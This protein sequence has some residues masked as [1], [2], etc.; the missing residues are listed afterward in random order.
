[1]VGRTAELSRLE[2]AV[3]SAAAGRGTVALVPGEAGIGKTRLVSELGDRV[4]LS[5]STVLIGTCVAGVGSGLPYL[6][7][8]EAL[9]PLRL[10]AVLDELTG[11]LNELVQLIP[12]LG[13]AGSASTP[14]RRADRQLRIFRE[15]VELLDR[16][17]GN[18]ATVLVLEDLHWADASTLGLVSYLAHAVR[19]HRI[20]VVATYR[21]DQPG[22]DL[23]RLEVE[24]VRSGAATLVEL[25]PLSDQ[26]LAQLLSAAS[27]GRLDP[28]IVASIC[29][30]SEGNPFFAEE[31][32]A[33]EGAGEETVP[34]ILRDVLLQRFD[35]LGGKTRAVVRL[36]ASSSRA[37]PYRLLAAAA[38]CDGHD[39][40]EALREAVE[41]GVLVPDPAAGTFRFRHALLAEACYATVL[42]GEREEI[43]ARLAQALVDDP[44]SAA[45]PIAGELAHH[46]AAAG[47]PV[48]ALRASVSAAREA[49]AV[50]GRTET[51]RHLERVLELWRQV[52]DPGAIAGLDRDEVLR[53]AAE[54]AHFGG[55][56]GRAAE[57][58][59]E[60]LAE[61]SAEADVVQLGMM[62]ERLGTYLLPIGE[63]GAAMAAYVRALELV[64]ADPPSAERATVLASY[65]R[66]LMLAGRWEESTAACEQ[67]LALGAVLDDERPTLRARAVLGVDLCLLGAGRVAVTCLLRARELARE[68]GSV[69]D[70]LHTYV[71]LSD[72][73]LIQG[74]LAEAAAEALEGL[75][76]SRQHGYQRSSG[77]IL[78]ANAAEAL[79]A[80]GEWS[81]A[82][83]VL[84]RTL[85]D[86]GGF[87]PEGVHVVCAQVAIGRG[88]LG[89]AHEHLELGARA[90][91]EPQ[92]K[93]A[94]AALQAEVALWEGGFD[95]ALK[96]VDG[97]LHDEEPG[98]L[99]YREPHL[100]ALGL[101][102]LV[103]RVR[104]AAIRRDAAV[105]ADTRRSAGVLLE[106]ARSSVARAAAVSPEASGWTAVAE[107]EHTRVAGLP[108]PDR[109]QD[110]AAIWEQLHRPYPAAYCRW[111]LAEALL[112]AGAP[113]TDAVLPA[114][115]AHRTARRLGAPLLLHDVE[116]LA[117]RA[118]LDL[119]G[120]DE[121]ATPDDGDVLGL[122]AREREVLQL[123]ARGYTNREIASE[124]A[125]S[126][127]TASVHV[128]HILRKLDVTRR[129]EAAE[130][131]HGL[132]PPSA[133]PERLTDD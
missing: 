71:Q 128:S 127:K 22:E 17:G 56:P 122:T 116:Q 80:L 118:R 7:L 88:R 57:L 99:R 43:H 21:I 73:L 59:R 126:V 125:M 72:A 111:R 1:L 62:H 115:E 74:R 102:V 109:W 78:G 60:A 124:L 3:A 87:R 90:S 31:L 65:G 117:R 106:R 76:K 66:G 45:R 8:V 101:R 37:I 33:A 54:V 77:V 15:T 121:S 63:R 61:P 112:A 69:Q 5:G 130:I 52:D 47:R 107:S 81:R 75:D 42:P 27:V 120:S 2:D 105:V 55:A 9:R 25:G 97:A 30:R 96:V 20:L 16:V 85:R 94:F 11:D 29:D 28:A 93:A 44:A 108:N 92:A 36:A 129:L 41:L 26:E 91:T 103:E 34:R 100:C 6:P 84:D 70:E 89:L 19:E 51:L 13:A 38:P 4:R 95:L 110:A 113:R 53:W 64:P 50:A 35:Q 10:T 82:E 32:L 83:E 98:D 49:E 58:M 114:R 46:W 104:R 123:L 79:F 24:L 40:M 48:E 131:A 119:A 12:E 86:T 132:M 68:Y 67:A 14:S 133:A 23:R 39:L 18:Q